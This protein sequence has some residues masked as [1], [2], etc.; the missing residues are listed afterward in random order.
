MT[1]QQ[2]EALIAAALNV[3][4]ISVE[5]GD[6]VHFAALIVS[7]DFDGK[8]AVARHQLVYRAL[9]DHMREDIHALSIRALTPAEFAA[10]G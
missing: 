10:E 5:S 8:R 7:P 4:R 9:G 2:I 1:P 6:N 3:E